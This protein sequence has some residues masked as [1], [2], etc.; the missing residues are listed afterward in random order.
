MKI[1]FAFLAVA[2]L[3][4]TLPAAAFSMIERGSGFDRNVTFKQVAL[5]DGSVRF[6]KG[7]Y[8]VHIQ[9]TGMGDGSVLAS[10]FD[11]TGRKA[12]EAHGI[13]AVL[14]SAGETKVVPGGANATSNPGPPGRQATFLSLGF[15]ANS[16]AS[17]RTEGSQLKLVIDGEGQ[18]QILIGLLLPAVQKAREAAVPPAQHAPVAA[19]GS[20]KIKN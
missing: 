20:S 17:F 8:R 6:E 7:T 15:H 19:P 4:A 5:G 16:P 3:A 13:I 14:G 11:K 9:A 18:N 12:G 2:V 1:R 10:F